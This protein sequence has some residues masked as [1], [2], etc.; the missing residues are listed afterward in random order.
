M[1]L[2][3]KKCNVMKKIINIITLLFIMI[4]FFL[5]INYYFSNSHIEMI[6]L[7]RDNYDIKNYN[8]TNLPII[9]SDTQG[10]IEYNTGY[11]INKSK[12]FKRSFWELFKN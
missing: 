3:Q 11:D 6:K 9:E 10:I 5:I 8:M 7:K 4:F 2:Y 12:N 1:F